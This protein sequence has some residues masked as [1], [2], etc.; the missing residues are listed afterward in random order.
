MGK[1]I[2]YDDA[3][4]LASTAENISIYAKPNKYNYRININSPTI[5]PMYELYKRKYK[6]IVM[7]DAERHDFERL[8]FKLIEQGKIKETSQCI[9]SQL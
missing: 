5:K 8:I 2:P 3:L 6:I 4:K 9:S 1:K 7:S